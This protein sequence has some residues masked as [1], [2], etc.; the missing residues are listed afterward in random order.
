MAQVTV[1]VVDDEQEIRDLVEVYLRNEGY[2][3]LT[4][5]NGRDALAMVTAQAIDLVV[6]DIMMPG[7]DGV[8]TCMRIRQEQQMPIIMLSA[9]T[10]DLDKIHGLTAGA[11]DYVA[12][13]FN[14]LE[15]VARVKSQLRRHL[16]WGAAATPTP[17]E[18]AVDDLVINT[19]A[20][21][22]TVN[23]RAVS[24][25]PTEFAILELLARNRGIVFGAER[26]YEQVWNEP[27]FESANTVMVHIRKLREKLE[28][29]PRKPKYIK[30]VWGVGYRI[31]S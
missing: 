21:T 16:Q 5:G 27:F 8:Q 9:R 31:E 3:V 1:L 22:V 19:A 7:M 14:P 30:T 18:I 13:P 4:A 28:E 15:L 25:T 6:L 10:E 12:K 2:R 23:G 29:Q 26:I 17:D 11:D 20:H 24:L